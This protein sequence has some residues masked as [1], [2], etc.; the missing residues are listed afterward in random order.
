MS[1]TGCARVDLSLD[2]SHDLS[3]HQ[4]CDRSAVYISPY[5]L[6]EITG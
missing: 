5:L 1:A 4:I 2:L 6:R 3:C